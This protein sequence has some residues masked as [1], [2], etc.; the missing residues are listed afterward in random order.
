MAEKKK[1]AMVLVLILDFLTVEFERILKTPL[2]L[3]IAEDL[4]E[5]R[6]IPPPKSLGL[7]TLRDENVH[8]V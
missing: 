1:I 5:N 2:F 3:S 8:R 4:F 7:H 6:L